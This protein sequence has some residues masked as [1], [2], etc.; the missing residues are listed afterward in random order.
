[1]S[2]EWSTSEKWFVFE[3]QFVLSVFRSVVISENDRQHILRAA[4]AVPSAQEYF[5][6]TIKHL[7]HTNRIAVSEAEDMIK[8]LL[9]PLS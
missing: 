4:R 8:I 2:R 6:Q 7:Q 3:E 5:V 9:T 1:M